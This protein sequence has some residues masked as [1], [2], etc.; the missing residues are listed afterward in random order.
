VSITRWV[1][2]PPRD[3]LKLFGM[4]VAAL[5]RNG[6]PDPGRR[7]VLIRGW[8]TATLLVKNGALS[9]QDIE[10]ARAFCRERSFDLGWYPG[11]QA[12][13]ADRYNALEQPYF[14]DGAVALLGQGRAQFIDRYKFY[15]APATDDRP[16][17]FRFFEGRTLTEL[18]RLQ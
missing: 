9:A 17:F 12:H 1:T 2:L 4:A 16:Y 6:V 5:E 11:M 8:K 18:L 7:L 15:V 10:R 13:E 3:M 14:Y